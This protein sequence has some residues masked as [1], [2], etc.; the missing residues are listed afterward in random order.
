LPGIFYGIYHADR[1]CK[2]VGK[3]PSMRLPHWPKQFA[4]D[5]K[6]LQLGRFRSWFT[7]VHFTWCSLF[8]PLLW[9]V[10]QLVGIPLVQI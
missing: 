10:S 3:S 4:Q 5:R 6:P 9:G 8:S 1:C 7:S 2:E